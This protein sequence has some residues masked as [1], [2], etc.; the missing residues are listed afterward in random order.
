MPRLYTLKRLVFKGSHGKSPG[1][2]SF[3]PSISS[4]HVPL[5][6]VQQ[7]EGINQLYSAPSW[8]GE[9]L[10]RWLIQWYLESPKL[11]YQPW[12]INHRN[13]QYIYIHIY[14]YINSDISPIQSLSRPPSPCPNWGSWKLVAKPAEMDSCCARLKFITCHPGDPRWRA[15]RTWQVWWYQNSSPH[16]VKICQFVQE[17]WEYVK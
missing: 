15:M 10:S 3:Q 9:W 5:R 13:I 8:G 12:H 7:P 6:H 16:I 4:G 1:T 11:S 14:P 17:F 2:S